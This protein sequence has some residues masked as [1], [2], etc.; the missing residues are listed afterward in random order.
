MS[1]THSFIGTC[2]SNPFHSVI[3][4]DAVVHGSKQITRKT[5]DKHCD[6]RFV[7]VFED[8]YKKLVNEYPNDFTFHKNKAIYFF[9]HSSVEFFFVPK[10]R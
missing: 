10:R 9:T 2:I 3:L 1:K 8:D 5:F 4:L 7:M 6:T